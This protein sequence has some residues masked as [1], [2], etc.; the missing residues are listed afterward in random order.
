MKL[1]K[2]TGFIEMTSLGLSAVVVGGENKR[3]EKKMKSVEEV[4]I[5]IQ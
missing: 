4:R 3:K 2:D 5:Q 1:L